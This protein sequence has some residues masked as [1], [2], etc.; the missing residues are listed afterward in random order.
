MTNSTGGI[1][2]QYSYGPYGE[3]LAM[4]EGTHNPFGYVGRWG[5]MEE[6]DGL[7]YMR[8]RFYDDTTGRFLNQDPLGFRA[9]VNPYVS[10]S[11]DPVN[12][13]DPLGLSKLTYN[14]N[15]NTRTLTTTDGN[16]QTF[17]AYN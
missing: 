1:V 4:S 15:I 13:I 8:A 7:K 12:L 16:C 14:K 3:R 2:N 11:N 6:G 10:V 17:P 5:V 9:G